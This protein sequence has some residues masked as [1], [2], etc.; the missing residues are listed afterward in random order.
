MMG[1]GDNLDIERYREKIGCYIQIP[2]IGRGKLKYVGP[3]ESKQGYFA[4][5]DLLANIGK[6]N[7][8]YNGRRYFETKYPL[9]GL[10]IQ[11]PK[12]GYLIER[13]TESTATVGDGNSVAAISPP[14]RRSTLGGGSGSS[15]SIG[16]SVMSRTSDDTRVSSNNFDGLRRSFLKQKSPTPVGRNLRTSSATF[17]MEINNNINSNSDNVTERGDRMH[18]MVKS[19]ST[20]GMSLE[21]QY[22][23]QQQH[24]KLMPPVNVNAVDDSWGNNNSNNVI[25]NVDDEMSIDMTPQSAARNLETV[26]VSAQTSRNSNYDEVAPQIVKDYELKIERQRRAISEYEKLLN[27][28]RVLLEE[29]QPVID[30]CEK[31]SQRL[32]Q[33]RDQLKEQ[34]EQEREQQLKQKQ[35]FE[36]EHEQLMDVLNRLR[37]EIN[38]NEKQAEEERKKR[39]EEEEEKKLANG[40]GGD[41]IREEDIMNS[42]IV[43][44]LKAKVEELGKYKADMEY[45]KTKW[46]KEREQLKMHTESL[47]KEYQ[48]LNKELMAALNKEQEAERNAKEVESLRKQLQSA[49]DKIKELTETTRAES[50]R[51]TAPT[52]SLP[53]YEPEKKVDAAAGRKQWC[54]LCERFGHIQIDCPFQNEGQLDQLRLVPSK[55]ANTLVDV[56]STAAIDG[57]DEEVEMY[58]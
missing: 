28:Q 57:A 1:R 17:R 20:M 13:A 46:D 43:Q 14:S 22:V 33:E 40:N 52:N 37:E 10:F 54:V 36:K 47:S 45:A 18:G 42:Q 19:A 7:G 25:D 49:K 4:G 30:A 35:Y 8:S 44:V 12:V 50:T 23:P 16:N 27:E 41:A 29:I 51:D 9:S 56:G 26:P 55:E 11:L 39:Q 58:Y 24:G 2:N 48:N 32:E 21:Q 3:V 53:L 31:K 38:E 6:N 34:L 5:I 15:R